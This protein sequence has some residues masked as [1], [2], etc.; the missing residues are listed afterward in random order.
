MDS[1]SGKHRAFCQHLSYLRCWHYALGNP[2]LDITLGLGQDSCYSPR[3]K[4]WAP[5]SLGWWAKMQ[6]VHR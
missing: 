3:E 6:R 4:E 5:Q 2:M 1:V